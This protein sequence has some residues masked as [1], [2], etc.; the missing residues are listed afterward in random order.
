[1]IRRAG[2]AARPSNEGNAVVRA[3][4]LLALLAIVAAIAWGG[5]TY[6]Q[7]TRTP[8]NVRATG[9]TLEI[10]RGEGFNGIVSPA[11]IV[12]TS[13]GAGAEGRLFSSEGSDVFP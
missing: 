3:L 6:L 2:I 13:G 12:S 9:Q 8:L 7:F 4:L 5:I 10:A 1:M 11:W